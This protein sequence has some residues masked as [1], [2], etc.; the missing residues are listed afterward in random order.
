MQAYEAAGANP[1]AV[2]AFDD[3]LLDMIALEM[4]APDPSDAGDIL[5]TGICEVHVH[6]PRPAGSESPPRSP[7]RYSRR[8][9]QR[10]NRPT[11]LRSK[12]P[13]ARP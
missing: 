6:E 11:N 10:S 4:A 8:S 9:R 2:D 1:E 7:S 3:A 13:L 5:N 12:F